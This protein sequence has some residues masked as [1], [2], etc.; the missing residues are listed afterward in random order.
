MRDENDV[1]GNLVERREQGTQFRFRRFVVLLDGELQG[2]FEERAGFRTQ[3]GLQKIFSE[4]NARHHPIGFFGDAEF[5]MRSRL[6]FASFGHEGLGQTETEKFVGGIAIDKGQKVRRAGG[7]G[8]MIQGS[9]TNTS[10]PVALSGPP[11]LTAR[12]ISS[13]KISSG[14]SSFAI[15]SAISS[16]RTMRVTPS[17]QKK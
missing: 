12:V 1:A 3:A 14:C 11:R 9:S 16:S 8:R 13:R 15:R 7:H 10:T 6:R 17:V 5:E 2:V 4:Q